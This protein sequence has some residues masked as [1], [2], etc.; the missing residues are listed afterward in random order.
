VHKASGLQLVGYSSPQYEDTIDEV[1]K[2]WLEEVWVWITFCVLL[3]REG[4]TA[5][6]TGLLGFIGPTGSQDAEVV[7]THGST[8]S[9]DYNQ[10]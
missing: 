7:Q 4:P 6:I 2:G 8:H 5:V 9:W 10:V 3:P 1:K